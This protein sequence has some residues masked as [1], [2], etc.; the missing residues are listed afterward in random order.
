MAD[1]TIIR[2]GLD[3]SQV[4][5]GEKEFTRSAAR[6]EG[7]A[8]AMGKV[9]KDLTHINDSGESWIRKVT[10]GVVDAARLETFASASKGVVQVAKEIG[11]A[12][13]SLNGVKVSDATRDIGSAFRQMAVQIAEANKE[14]GKSDLKQLQEFIR[15]ARQAANLARDLAAVKAAKPEGHSNLS[16]AEVSRR[17][18]ALRAA[19][20]EEAVAKR[21][22]VSGER[23]LE[24]TRE[25][26]RAYEALRT[27][28]S[29]DVASKALADARLVVAQEQ[30]ITA[31]AEKQAAAKERAAEASLR[32]SRQEALAQARN[33]V[34]ITREQIDDNLRYAHS[35][36][37]MRFSSQELRNYLGLLSAG[38]TALSFT[39]INSAKDQERAFA[40]VARTTQL[41][42][43]GSRSLRNLSD[44]MRD[45][46]ANDLSNPYEDLSRIA[47]LGAQMD[48]PIHRLQDFTEAV[49][50]FTT[51]TD[52]SVDE[53][54]ESFGRIINTFQ[55]A[56]IEL[57]GAST[58]EEYKQLASQVSELGARSVATEGEILKMTNSIA[59]SAVSAGI[60]QD[61]V[62]GYAATLT[63]IGVKAEWARGSLQRIFGKFNKS[64]AEG[65]QEMESYARLLGIS[66]DEADRLWRTDPSKFFNEMIFALNNIKDPIEKA[67][68]I[69]SIG[70]VNTRDVQLLQR[71]SVNAG[72]LNKAMRDS[73][74]A[75]S[76]TEFFD[77]SLDTLNSTLTETINR[78][79][80]SFNNMAAT[81]GEPFLGPIK[82]IIESLNKMMQVLTAIGSTPVGR[83]FAAFAGGVV[84]FASL[85][86]AAKTVQFGIL[87]LAS[88]FIQ[89]RQRMAEIGVQGPLTWRNIKFAI[90]QA[91]VGVQASIPLYHRLQQ[92]MAVLNDLARQHRA[93]SAQ[94]AVARAGGGAVT[95]QA[96]KSAKNDAAK[97]INSTTNAMREQV[98]WS[99]ML[100]VSLG[101]QAVTTGV[102]STAQRGATAATFGLK[103]AF[104][105][106]MGSNPLGWAAMAI[107][108][109]PTVI[110]LID[111]L[112]ESAEEA[113]EKARASAQDT[114][115]ALGGGEDFLSS[116]KQ[117]TLNYSK[118]VQDSYSNLTV[119]VGSAGGAAQDAA[120]QWYYWLDA[121]GNIVQATKETAEAQDLLALKVGKSTRA[122]MANAFI[123]TEEF[124]NVTGDQL[125]DLAETGFDW[126]TYSNKLLAGEAG[127]ESAEAY[128][129]SVID[130]INKRLSSMRA[131]HII[132]QGD[133]VS[134]NF[135]KEEQA[136]VDSL[137][138]QKESL[139]SVKD[140]VLN[141]GGAFDTAAQQQLVYSQIAG[142]SVGPIEDNTEALEKQKEE[143]D[144]L[145][146]AMEKYVETAFSTL[147]G[148]AA[149]YDALDALN[150]SV[151]D[152]GNTFD[153]IT[154]EGREN[155]AALEEYLNAVV[156]TATDA[157]ESMGL[158]G[159][160]A[161]YYVHGQVQA[162]IDQLRESGFDL[163]GV[164]DAINNLDGI[165]SAEVKGPTV[166]TS[167]FDQANQNMVNTAVNTVNE[168]NSAYG[169]LP[170]PPS[171]AGGRAGSMGSA[172]SRVPY[173]NKPKSQ[174]ILERYYGK[175]YGAAKQKTSA[176]KK[177]PDSFYRGYGE[178]LKRASKYQWTPKEKKRGGG[179]GGSPRR[180]SGSGGGGGRGSNRREKTPQEQ[181]EDYL[182]RL[183]SAMKSA[184]DAFWRNQDAQD[185]YHSQLNRMTKNIKDARKNIESLNEEV[186]DLYTT[187]NDQE[188][189]LHDAQYFNAIAKKYGDTERIK[190]TQNNID[191]ASKDIDKTRKSIDDKRK[192]AAEI[193][194]NMFVLTGFTDAAIDNRAALKSLQQQMIA[195]IQD[196]AAQGHST[197]E[198]AQYTQQLKQE[199]INQATQMGFNRDEVVKLSGAFDSLTSTVNQVPRVVNIEVS[200]NG[201]ASRT[202][203]SIGAAAS[204]NGYGYHAG[205][206]AYADGAALAVAS[207]KLAYLARDRTSTVRVRVVNEAGRGQRVYH[208]DTR[209]HA[210]AL[211]WAHGGRVNKF[212]GGGYLNA[213][214][215]GNHH[216]DNLRG[217]GPNGE[218]LSLQGGEF[219][220][221]KSAV[222]FYGTGL[223]DAINSHRFEPMTVQAAPVGGG[224]VTLDPNQLHQLA[225]AVS[226]VISLDGRAISRNINKQYSVDGRRGN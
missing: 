75:G 140:Q 117:D 6:V 223:L 5:K 28:T 25:R 189:E 211:S 168:I 87:N 214:S 170:G 134:Y 60:G 4:V 133:S 110:T 226:T 207:G 181:F 145:V 184:L 123:Q 218:P 57:N 51:I 158:M 137:E 82:V 104:Q 124:K 16:K 81:F 126:G 45:M 174:Q 114:L 213:Y 93:L 47:S 37:Q 17:Q 54:A 209:T 167:A 160:T 63:S 183:S 65:V 205:V 40:D 206:S 128:V 55:Q 111:E 225:R 78:F 85:S 193:K 43:E 46:S 216:A 215:G 76:S 164:E 161:Q 171:V 92:E 139:Q 31:E 94:E 34:S 148:T 44:A 102:V 101:T 97:N 23:L 12:T 142:E 138:R 150:Q 166:D 11:N 173:A 187:L 26:Q 52:V 32:A 199:F 224:Q 10:P 172:F 221:R 127:A 35:L 185:G 73:A 177:A 147:N 175:G 79:R 41:S 119:A 36:E 68:A 118:G 74:E 195:M 180:G 136:L 8:K 88:S 98:S 109:L 49:G 217:Y 222:N 89:M 196:Y 182:K 30:R 19:V 121:Q 86:A 146:E 122:L 20:A 91:R 106:L 143:W 24:V 132:V 178:A 62:L 144:K 22:L 14:I 38:V 115:A 7:A 157:A 3:A 220:V 135:T 39:F 108:L 67:Q 15:T 219:V 112:Y 210:Q 129:Q 27:A 61:E 200:D 83:V 190:S 90:D 84:M 202:G 69:S 198:V 103:G 58:R 125:R 18:D 131:D 72:L 149:V 70:I 71:M 197:Q 156:S 159:E 208:G 152:N 130:G 53:A 188:Q 212:A 116:I 96:A 95:G 179:G 48:I 33:S 105:A 163:T 192:E 1:E 64:S 59:A 176:T 191:R 194:R 162:A 13:R 201:S 29:T 113:R 141:V 155:I 107:S 56:G 80:N 21:N 50:G 186:R 203:A 204:N 100:N 77:R 151:N 2:L 154:S 9:I 165:T 66:A 153:V 42:A 169:S 120:D 99:D